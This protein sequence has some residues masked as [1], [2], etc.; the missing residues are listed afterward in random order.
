MSQIS[1]LSHF[2]LFTS[3]PTYRDSSNFYHEPVTLTNYPMVTGS[4][5]VGIECSDCV[6]I[7]ADTLGSYGSLSRFKSISR[8]RSFGMF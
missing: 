4:S 1:L 3:H 8:I 5:V 7:A 6:L 2:P